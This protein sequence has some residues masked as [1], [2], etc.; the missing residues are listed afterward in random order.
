MKISMA[1][2]LNKASDEEIQAVIYELIDNRKRWEREYPE[3]T[4][5]QY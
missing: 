5:R 2:L 4:L 3:A 1:S